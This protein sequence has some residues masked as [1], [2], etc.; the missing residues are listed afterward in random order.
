MHKIHKLHIFNNLEF[1][2]F[3]ALFIAQIKL[4]RLK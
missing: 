1:G 4:R 2:M 3:F